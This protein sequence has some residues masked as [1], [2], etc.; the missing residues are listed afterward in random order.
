MGFYDYFDEKMYKLQGTKEMKEVQ[1]QKLVARVNEA[2]SNNEAFRNYYS[3]KGVKAEDVS[4]I[5]TI[6]DFKKV[7]PPMGEMRS[8]LTS[9]FSQIWKGNLVDTF[10]YVSGLTRGDYALMCATSGTTGMPTPYFFTEEDLGLM[11]KGMSRTFYMCGMG[12]GDLVVHAF[13]LS[14]FGAGIPMVE[15]LMRLGIAV[16]PVGAEA[17]KDRLFS[18]SDMFKPTVICCTP[19]YAGYLIDTEPDKVKALELKRVM[20]GGEAG[21]GIP[22]VRKK[23][24]D[25]FGC[26]LTDAM[27]LI[28]GMALVSCDLEEYA[29]MHHLSDDIFLFELVD[30][31]TKEPLPFED[32]VIGEVLI[33]PLE[34]ATLGTFT[35]VS[36]GDMGQ[37]F[38]EPCKCGAPGWRVKVVGRTDDM[39]K[40]KGVIVYPSHIKGLIADFAPRVT[41]EFRVVLDAPPPRVEPPLKLKVEYGEGVKQEELSALGSEISEVMH[42]KL[43]VRPKIEWLSPNTLERATHKTQYIEKTYKKK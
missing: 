38:T 5:K 9:M 1:Q 3:S 19:S 23:I 6:E 11:A 27:G 33:T 25:G 29:G 14:M 34:G 22:E 41:G 32:G 31:E 39:L 36:L 26:P 13:A 12:P 20:C 15:A 17:G 21:G 42:N 10:A 35:R 24:Q 30:P 2:Y 37:V 7:F 43:H 18:Y 8:A 16:M 40:V 28:G 4:K